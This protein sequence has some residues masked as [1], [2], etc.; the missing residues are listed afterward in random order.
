MNKIDLIVR[1]L[2]GLMYVV[3][4]LNG[5]LN[6]M[7]EPP[8][9]PEKAGILMGA[10][11]AVGYMLPLI[12]GTEVLGGLLLL[13]GRFAALGLVILA[14]ITLNIVLFHAMLAPE[15]MYLQ[16][17]MLVAH[18]FLMWRRWPIYRPMFS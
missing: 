1:I 15:N 9:M 13:S 10:F 8:P 16:I 5:F 18:V 4:G 7:G 2:L 12:K 17:G 3:F 6:F 14:P 11:M